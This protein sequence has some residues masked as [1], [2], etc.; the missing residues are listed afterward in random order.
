MMQG[1]DSS[2][3]KALRGRDGRLKD[4]HLEVLADSILS[5]ANDVGGEDKDLALELAE[6]IGKRLVGDYGPIVKVEDIG[7]V[8]FDYLDTQGYDGTAWAFRI[9][10][11]RKDVARE[12]M[13]VLGST[14][15]SGNDGT[16]N[17]L[18]VGSASREVS[19]KWNRERIIASLINE[20]GLDLNDARAVAEE[21]ETN[22]FASGSQ[23]ITTQLIREAVHSELIRRRF[24]GAANNYRNFSIPRADLEGLIFTKLNENANIAA[25]NPE[26]INFALAGGT[27]KAY[28]LSSVFS[29]EV[30][31]AHTTGAVHVHDLDMPTRLYC[32][33]HSLEYIKKYGLRLKNLSSKSGSAKHAATLT[34]HLNTFLASMQTYYAGALGVGDINVF[35]APHLQKDL[36]EEGIKRIEGMKEERDLLIQRVVQG[37]AE[38]KENPGLE[39]LLENQNKRIVDYEADPIS[40]LPERFVDKFLEQRAQELIYNGSQNAFSRGGQTLFLDF[41]VHASVP[42]HLRNT[43]IILDGKYQL[44][45]SEGKLV[46]LE[47]RALEQK[48]KGGYNLMELVDPRN[49]KVVLKEGVRQEGGKEL[50]FQ[51][52]NTEEGESLAVYGD[53]RSV[54]RKFTKAMLKKFGEGDYAGAAFA[55][56]KCDFHVNQDIFEDSEDSKMLDEACR[57]ASENGSPYFV[58]DRDAVTMSACCRLRTTIED[59]YPILHPETMRF[60]GFQNVTVNMPQAAY[61]AARNDNK[62]LEGFLQEID[63]TME[64]AVKAHKEKKGFVERL[65]ESGGPQE[66]TGAPS[67]DGRPYVNLDNATYIIGLIGLNDAV[68]FLTGKQLHEL[69]GDEFKEYALGTVAHM[70]SKA[71]ELSSR[72]G[73]KF[74]LE[75][76]PAESATRRLSMID[77]S[78]YPESEEVIKG[79]LDIGDTYYTNSIHL[80]P[81]ADVDLST[82]IKA[83]GLFHPAIDSGAITH[84]FVEDQK[85]SPASIRTLVEKTFYNTETAQL[86]ISPEFTICNSCDTTSRGLSETCPTCDS[87]DVEGMSRIV[88]YFS[89]IINWNKSKVQELSDRHQ[90]RYG[91]EDSLASKLFEMPG[92]EGGHNGEL[93]VH[94]FGKP[95]CGLCDDVKAVV[96]KL[97]KPLSRKLQED[98]EVVERYHDVYTGEGMTEF[99]TAGLNTSRLPAV[100]VMKGG[101]ELYRQETNYHGDGKADLITVGSM[102]RGISENW[103]GSD[104]DN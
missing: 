82:R 104:E 70:N 3:P 65:Q 2:F 84:A 78:L 90:G 69:S 48:T 57:V 99:L 88:G 31:R 36:E 98:N 37:R 24:E 21:A 49:G 62:T 60:C 80:S 94:R 40:V 46:P 55:F 23:D 17:F 102:T 13:S 33:A 6:G 103:R 10:H 44:K 14:A 16:D 56:P 38:S 89:R 19:T 67:L 28:A 5:A 58:F 43:P 54:A 25:N 32:S 20:A 71:R 85:P 86:T 51:A 63:A 41:N 73:L 96:G 74:S 64:T 66:Q 45:N 35:F 50:V 15:G 39:S 81:R 76:S 61:R 53:Y 42:S 11:R 34:G 7:E 101:Q 92:L 27:L 93:V 47:E 26:A 100:V 4:F 95:G 22:I 79:D 18:M 87:E 97:R 91:V 68:Q 52:V 59:N 9:R 30:A 83:Q 1:L 29:L 77:R 8:V 75:E 72:E 12:R